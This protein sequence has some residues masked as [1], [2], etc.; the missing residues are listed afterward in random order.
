MSKLVCRLFKCIYE[1]PGPQKTPFLRVS[2]HR[3]QQDTNIRKAVLIVIGLSRHQSH[4]TRIH[5]LFRDRHI[6]LVQHIFERRQGR[7]HAGADEGKPNG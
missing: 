6:R 5:A 3:F 2:G 4:K 7:C 1:L